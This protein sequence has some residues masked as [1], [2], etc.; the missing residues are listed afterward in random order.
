MYVTCID[1]GEDKGTGN[2]LLTLGRKYEVLSQLGGYYMVRCD[3][4]NL[5]SK[6]KLRFK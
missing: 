6:S 3:D 4:G 5:Y 2:G 1:A